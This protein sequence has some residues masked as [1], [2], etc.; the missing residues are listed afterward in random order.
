M[1]IA[2]AG[3][4]AN[5]AKDDGSVI[6]TVLKLAIIVV[7]GFILVAAAVWVYLLVANWDS[8]KT[9]AR[10]FYAFFGGG[11]LGF[12]NPFSSKSDMTAPY[13]PPQVRNTAKAWNWIF[14]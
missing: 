3:M 7:I 12:L 2:V 13:W 8:I 9:I 11:L 1:V 4:A 5:E 14:G 6:N 10:T